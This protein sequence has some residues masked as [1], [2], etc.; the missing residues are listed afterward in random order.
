MSSIATII[1]VG[2]FL[3]ST[4]LLDIVNAL[5]NFTLF[6]FAFQFQIKI[7]SSLL[8]WMF[9]S[10]NR[11]LAKKLPSRSRSISSFAS[12]S[13]NKDRVENEEEDTDTKSQLISCSNSSIRS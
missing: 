9:E 3:I 6:C 4:H 13:F 12:S 10:P 5:A 1:V 11:Q 7:F 8:Y 2:L